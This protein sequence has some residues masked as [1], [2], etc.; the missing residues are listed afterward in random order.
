MTNNPCPQ[1]NPQ[2]DYQQLRSAIG[3]GLQ[4]S[5]AEQLLRYLSEPVACKT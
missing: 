3:P 5:V 2:L 1:T 4:V